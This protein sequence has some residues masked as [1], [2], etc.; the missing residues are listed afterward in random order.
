MVERRTNLCES[1]STLKCLGR[2][3]IGR[4]GKRRHGEKGASWRKSKK[5]K[6]T[7]LFLEGR[8][9]CGDLADYFSRD[10]EGG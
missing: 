1:F 6:S 5:R 3:E 7:C 10:Q 2:G 8:K 9:E 4:L